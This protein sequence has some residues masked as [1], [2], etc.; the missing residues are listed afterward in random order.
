VKVLHC[1]RSPVGGLFRHVQDLIRYQAAQGVATGIICGLETGGDQAEKVLSD[2]AG[3][4]DLG[5]HRVTITRRPSLSDLRAIIQ[6]GEICRSINPDI[7]HGHGAKGGAFSRLLAHRIAAHSIYT[8]HGGA[9]HYNPLSLSGLVYFAL[10]RLLRPNTDAM[11]F[12]SQFSA[13][14]Y[15]QKIGPIPCSYKVIHNGV[16]EA[17]LALT[18]KNDEKVNFLFLGEFRKLKGLDIFLK[19][20]ALVNKEKSIRIIIAGYGR[21]SKNIGSQIKELGLDGI[22]EISPPIFPASNALLRTDCM[23]VP[24]RAESLPYIVLEAAAA[25]IPLIATNVGG[26]PEIFGPYSDQLI[27]PESPDALA[28]EMLRALEQPHAKQELATKLQTRISSSFLVNNMGRDINAFYHNV[29]D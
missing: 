24:S 13:R 15:E 18:A 10:E 20:A 23:I 14:A 27:P 17:E 26:I 2:L 19:A 16:S 21:E 28:R 8:P 7:I 5:V 3:I 25:G 22:I 12:E 6:A 1:F 4:C 11:I 29:I 9:L